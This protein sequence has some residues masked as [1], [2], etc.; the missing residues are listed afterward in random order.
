M[1][2]YIFP[3]H[4][5]QYQRLPFP[6]TKGKGKKRKKE[7]KG[8]RSSSDPLKREEKEGKRPTLDRDFIFGLTVVQG[9]KGGV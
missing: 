9:K 3:N 2:A 7:G 1:M 8:E 5:G 4:R 6:T